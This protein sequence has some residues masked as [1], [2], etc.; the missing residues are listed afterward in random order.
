LTLGRNQKA[1]PSIV[2][3]NSAKNG[4]VLLNSNVSVAEDGFVSINARWL[5][6][7]AGLGQGDFLLDSEWP[8]ASA[9]LPAGMPQI[10][11]GPYM[12]NR[13]IVKQNGLTYVDTTYVS[14]LGPLRISI[15]ATSSKSSFSGYAENDDGDSESLSFDYHVVSR[16]YS[17]AV[18]G[19]YALR[20]PPA[21]PGPIY[22]YRREGRNG[23]VRY[24]PTKSV[25]GTRETL[26]R[27]N[28]Y[29]LTASSIYEQVNPD[30]PTL[31]VH[32]STNM[33]FNE[34]NLIFSY[35]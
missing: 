27:V 10:Q 26:G 29:Q 28:R 32:D 19:E 24:K 5:A 16:T 34:S 14:A 17:F 9:A 8:L 4:L 21:A 7:A 33:L 6:P 30:F 31:G 11:S 15:S 2:R 3:R 18:V 23:L 12:L 25:T 1:M 35:G 22:N 20:Q 13:T